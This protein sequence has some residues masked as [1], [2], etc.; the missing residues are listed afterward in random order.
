[1]NN[2]IES[3]KQKIREFALERDWE[4]Y[5][6]PKNLAMALNVE[7]AELLEIFQWISEEESYQ[8][9][10][11]QLSALKEEIGD[12]L[13][14]LTGLADKFD[15]DPIGCA[16]AKIELNKTKYPSNI[17]KGSSKKYSDY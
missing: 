4:K 2:N 11:S 8:L 3:L 10:E 9:S 17:V 5:H 7:A 14:Y 13:I 16:E 12:V 6:S 1:M 15:L